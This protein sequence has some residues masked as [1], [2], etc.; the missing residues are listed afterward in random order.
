[1]AVK[2]KDVAQA[3][4]VSIATVSYVLNNSAPVSE[5]TRRRVMDAANRLGYRPN[6]TARNLKA[7]ETR[8]IG[9][10]WHNVE[11][12]QMNAVLDRFIYR[13]AQ[14]A[15]LRGYHVMTFTLP[16]VQG[17]AGD[18]AHV[19]EELIRTSRVD[20]FIVAE[21]DRNDDRIEHLL[22]LK[23]PFVAFGRANPAWD[24]PFVDVDVKAGVRLAV[25]HLL[26]LGHRR[27]ACLA[28]QHGLHNGDERLA[29]YL[30]TLQA[31]GIVPCSEWIARLQNVIED[32][33]AA[34]QTLMALPAD[35]RPT[36]IVSLSDVMAI[37]AMRYLESADIRI[38]YEVA[39]TGFDDDP[40]SAFINPPL[41]TLHQPID[42][43]GDKVIEMLIGVITN[44]PLAE[45]AVLIEPALIVRGSSDPSATLKP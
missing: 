17:G 12:N 30:E 15:E 20:G 1:M 36:A 28:W 42:A 34:T 33:Y 14:A 11:Q 26:A 2:I 31:A 39:L 23:F 21:T 41:T 5:E 7:S 35:I 43:I 32:G 29:G 24:F 3:A 38:G 22:K 4:D 19:Y 13:M 27:I 16:T 40:I 18:R 6:S 25:E 9:Y 45:K 37:G 44:Q 8:I 10:A